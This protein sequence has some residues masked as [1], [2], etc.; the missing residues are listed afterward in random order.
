M[1]I[2]IFAFKNENSRKDKNANLF[3]HPNFTTIINF[4]K[5]IWSNFEKDY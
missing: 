5:S 1:I 2:I 4:N 3:Y